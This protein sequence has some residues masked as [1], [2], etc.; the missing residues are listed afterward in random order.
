MLKLFVGIGEGD[1]D[2]G[3]DDGDGVA[4]FVGGVGGELFELLVGGADGGDRHAGEEPA[5]EGDGDNHCAD[6]NSQ[7]DD[8][9]AA[10]FGD[11]EPG[12]ADAEVAEELGACFD[13]A[14]DLAKYYAIGLGDGFA[15]WIYVEGDGVGVG[16]GGPGEVAFG[17]EPFEVDAIVFSVFFVVAEAGFD[18]DA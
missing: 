3:L 14:G 1:L 13:A 17:G 10:G 7:I 11:F 6:A 5:D 4:E 15:V 9:L 8:E 16:E 12:V 18:V 2:V